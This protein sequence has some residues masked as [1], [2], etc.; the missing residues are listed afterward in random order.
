MQH[1]S[2]VYIGWVYPRASFS[3]NVLTTATSCRVGGAAGLLFLCLH[4]RGV[5]GGGGSSDLS[6]ELHFIFIVR[7]LSLGFQP[8]TTDGRRGGV[9]GQVVAIRIKYHTMQLGCILLGVI[10]Q[11]SRMQIQSQNAKTAQRAVRSGG[12]TEEVGETPAPQRC[13]RRSPIPGLI[14][15][16]RQSR[17]IKTAPRRPRVPSRRSPTWRRA[18]VLHALQ[19]AVLTGGWHVLLLSHVVLLMLE[20]P[21]GTLVL[22]AVLVTSPAR[23]SG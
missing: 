1:H 2:I 9:R 23:S 13:R 5:L 11:N 10:S 18:F 21:A 6:L 12:H 4:L 8:R 19:V 22:V 17:C 14:L 16:W 3:T 20:S 7:F 15:R